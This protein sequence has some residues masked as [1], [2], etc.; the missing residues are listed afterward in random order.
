M[1]KILSSKGQIRLAAI[2]VGLVIGHLG[3]TP[4]VAAEYYVSPTGAPTN[5]GSINSPFDLA[6]ALG[7]TSPARPG[8]TIWLRGGRYVGNFASYLVGSPAAPIIVR[9]YPGERATIDADTAQRTTPALTVN[10]SDTWYWGFEI[11][12]SSP[13][14]VVPGTYNPPRATSVW[15]LGPRTKFINLIIHDGEQGFGFWSTAVDSEMYGNL[16]Y[17]TGFDSDARGNGHA[18]YV[19]NTTG[20]KRIVDNIML[21]GFSFGIHAY[22]QNGRIDNIHMIGNTIFNEGILSRG[23]A[24]ANLF[25]GGGDP[26]F[27]V[28]QENY[29]YHSPFTS[30]G[31]NIELR[32]SCI[33]G[34]IVNNYAAGGTA[35]SIYCVSTTVTGNFFAGR[36]YSDVT[37]PNN[38]IRST[39]P[40]GVN[41]F[42]RP[43]QYE[44]GGRAN[45]TIFNW[46]LR[47]HVAVDL[48]AARFAVGTTYEL[49]DAQNYFG[50]PVLTGTY[51]GQPINVPM[52][53]LTV[54]RPVGN[55]PIIPPHTA[56]QFGAFILVRTTT[57]STAPQP[58]ASLSASP[59]SINAGQ[60][61]LLSWSS[62]N[63]TQV[64]IDNGVGVVPASGTA[65]VS[66]STTTTYTLTAGNTSGTVTKSA[67]VT[68]QAT[69]PPPG[70][71][72]PP[73]PGTSA[74]F[75]KVDTTTQG[76]WKGVYGA[77]GYSLSYD[78]TALPGYARMTT[79]GQPYLWS[80]NTTDVRALQRANTGRVAA[81]WWA[82]S[83]TVDV[84]IND[85]QTHQVAFYMLDWEGGR[86]QSVDVLDAAT[87]TVL[88][89]RMVSDFSRGQ[90]LVWQVAGHVRFRITR[91]ARWNAAYSGI[92][93]GGASSNGTATVSLSTTASSFT[94]PA[95][96]PLTATTTGTNIREVRFYAGSTMVGSDNASPYNYTWSGAPAGTHTI[97]ARATDS[98]GGTITSAPVAVT[99]EPPSNVG[100]SGA[101]KFIRTDTTTR[102]D[103]KN[104]YGRS[105]FSIA[106][107]I[108]ALPA[109][110]KV[111]IS[112]QLH[113]WNAAVADV[114]ALQ[115]SGPGRLA[116]MWWNE[117]SLIDMDIIDGASHQV[118]LYMLDWEGG[119]HQ[120]IDVL[121]AATGVVLDSRTAADFITGQYWIWQVSGR[122][123]FRI[124][125][126]ARWNAAVSGLF[127]E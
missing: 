6:T 95:E 115:R 82:E 37:Y 79:T 98:L 24:K 87:N 90:Y 56:P 61:A 78:A 40:T 75:V 121:D 52:M 46:D 97:T 32:P 57:P 47:S 123:R 80:A 43:N 64:T 83:A 120:R 63:A 85:G 54:A 114:R 124:T 117:V 59:A 38:T 84:T 89:T 7:R 35:M 23:G 51:D 88:D 34:R 110:A 127:F 19:Q 111:K 76:N 39:P 10:G 26:Q 105:G 113:L 42:V 103:W 116:A 14:R 118:A 125:R 30:A 69:N 101:A 107:D 25:M 74:K 58:T 55:A 5:P 4:A 94:A 104:V 62:A 67:V 28:I 8:D 1:V 100:G 66:P 86:T 126:L 71:P 33:S 16:I 27:P 60:S 50:P 93:F 48:S 21:N 36:T 45:I 72:P 122:V 18:V 9:Q 96:I 108:T 20:T 29:L 77:D 49:R 65:S 73:T 3:A 41:V 119:R 109:Y 22:T 70:N 31:R 81:F 99:V 11:T 112:G 91:L 92:F 12:D 106:G 53:G 102:G 44:A 2:L 13:I 15:V 68:V 17:N